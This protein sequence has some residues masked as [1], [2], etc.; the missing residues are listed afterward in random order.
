[1]SFLSAHFL[2]QTEYVL[3]HAKDSHKKKFLCELTL[4]VRVSS[5]SVYLPAA[6]W[7]E[8][9]NL[10]DLTLQD[11][12]MTEVARVDTAGLNN[13]R[14]KNDKMNADDGMNEIDRD[15]DS[16]GGPSGFV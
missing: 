15:R 7:W 13:D 5:G 1:V 9:L 12:K 2:H 8:Y 16:K 3:F 4:R 6:G 10:Q 11:W 14:L